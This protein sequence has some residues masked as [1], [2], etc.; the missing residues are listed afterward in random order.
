MDVGGLGTVFKLGAE[1]CNS[2][3][4]CSVPDSLEVRAAPSRDRGKVAEAESQRVR[5]SERQRGREAERQRG[6]QVEPGSQGQIPC[7]QQADRQNKSRSK[8]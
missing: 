7:S 8:A 6:R 2:V 3:H 1:L 4:V 5:E